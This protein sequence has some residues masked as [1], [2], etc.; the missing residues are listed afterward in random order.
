MAGAARPDP[1]FRTADP[2][3]PELPPLAVESGPAPAPSLD[4]AILLAEQI[5]GTW[6]G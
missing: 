3:W 2:R 5:G 4:E 6:S 1:Q